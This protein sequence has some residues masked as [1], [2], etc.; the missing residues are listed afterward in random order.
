MEARELFFATVAQ[1]EGFQGTGTHCVYGAKTVALTKQ[2]FA[3]FQRAT[4][5]DD[6]VERVHV[7]QIQR[8]WQAEGSQAAILAMSRAVSAQLDWLGH[9]LSPCEETHISCKGNSPQASPTSGE[10]LVLEPV[11]CSPV[12]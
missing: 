1:A 9:H 12:K 7:F 6:F 2:E 8:K 3:F 11:P 4:P 5:F 10:N